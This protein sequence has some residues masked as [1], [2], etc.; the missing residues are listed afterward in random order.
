RSLLVLAMVPFTLIGGIAGLAL[1][2]L[3]VS[4][5][6]A[7]GFIAGA[8]IS[9]PNGGIMVEH[10][11]DRIKQSA[12]PAGPVTE[13]AGGRRRPV[14]MARGRL[15]PAPGRPLAGHRVGDPAAVRSGDRRR[16][17]FR[18]RIYARPAAAPLPGLRPGCRGVTD[19]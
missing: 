19:L 6:A 1:T 16:H 8:G 4:I 14:A 17:H 2:G 18:Y 5:S 7:G 15:G 12:A 11:V 13:S 10:I 3:H 9:V